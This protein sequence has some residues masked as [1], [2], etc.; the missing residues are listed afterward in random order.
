MIDQKQMKTTRLIIDGMLESAELHKNDSDIAVVL[1]A[2]IN[3]LICIV[4]ENQI[5]I[6][7][8][9]NEIRE[10]MPYKRSY[11]CGPG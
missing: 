9:L 3:T 4:L 5:L 1:T 7:N 11:D 10:Q 8:E 2:T 6:M